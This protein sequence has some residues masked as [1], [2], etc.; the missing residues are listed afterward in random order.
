MPSKGDIK[1]G[2]LA[3]E[4]EYTTKE[5]VE[6]G[7]RLQAQLE[8]QGKV[9][10]LDRI[11]LKKGIL[12]NEQ[13]TEIE[14]KQGRRIIFCPECSNKLN[15]AIFGPGTRIRCPKCDTSLTVPSGVKYEVVDRMEAPKKSARSPEREKQETIK[16][17]KVAA[18]PP[19]KKKEEQKLDDEI[20]L[21][22]DDAPDLGDAAEVLSG[23]L[24]KKDKA[25]DVDLADDVE[26]LDGGDDDLGD[27]GDLGDDLGGDDDLKVK[28][29]EDVEVLDDEEVTKPQAKKPAPPVPKKPGPR[30][31][32]FKKK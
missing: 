22:D 9:T 31:D 15:V 2:Q 14:K 18:P 10:S 17:K 1:F 24:K 27:D 21:L 32:R 5:K 28:A 3:V 11:M 26:V 12:D 6:E 23:G 19:K 8:K 7:L 30:L 20:D 13:I 4:M 29:D 16:V 25:K